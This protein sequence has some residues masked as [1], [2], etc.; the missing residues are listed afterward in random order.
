VILIYSTYQSNR[1]IYILDFCFKSKGIAYQLTTNFSDFTSFNGAKINYTNQVIGDCLSI[2]PEGLLEETKLRQKNNLV[3]S[4][5]KWLLNSFDDIFS[6]LF[7]F[8]TCY[9]EYY[10]LERDKHDRMSAK[11]STIY[12]QNRLHKPNAD[13][14]V[15]QLWTDLKLDY[16]KIKALYST[17]LTFDI[18]SAWAYKNKGFKRTLASDIKDLLKGKGIGEKIKIRRGQLPDPFDTFEQIE[19]LAQTHQVICFFLLGNWGKYDKN[20]LWYHPKLKELIQSIST[21]MAI[22]IHPSYQ[23]YLDRNK[24]KSELQRLKD[25]S[26]QSITKS[27]QHY[28]KLSLPKSYTVLSDIGVID[29]YS[30]GFADAYGFRSGTCFKY[31]F[32]NLISNEIT[33]LTI[34]PITY[35]DGTLNQYLKLS[36]SESKKIVADLKTEIQSVGGNFCPLWHNETLGDSGIWKGWDFEEING[37]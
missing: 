28:L 10:I 35:M 30:M 14:I 21:K 7:F 26:T 20:T 33:H 24:V 15:K 1:L 16:S 31:P 37:L 25:I 5:K 12:C 32:F 23:S 11:T 27:R 9:E 4:N 3:Y 19:N 22:G 6:I 36:I 34:H 17:T 2:I 29:D 8:L 18:D 13:I